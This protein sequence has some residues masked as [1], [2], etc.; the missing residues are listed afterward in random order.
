MHGQATRITKRAGNYQ[1]A[2]QDSQPYRVLTVLAVTPGERGSTWDAMYTLTCIKEDAVESR[3]WRENPG[4]G[5][6]SAHNPK[7]RGSNP[8]LAT[9]RICRF[10]AQLRWHAQVQDGPR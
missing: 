8:P 5:Q 2:L 6:I 7:V 4:M 10:A 3:V 9:R 1:R